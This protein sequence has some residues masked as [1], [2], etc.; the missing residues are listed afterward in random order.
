MNAPILSSSD[1]DATPVRFCRAC[2]EPCATFLQPDYRKNATGPLTMSTCV[3]P[4]C[5]LHL[6]TL[7]DGADL[8]PYNVTALYDATTGKLLPRHIRCSNVG[9]CTREDRKL[10]S[11]MR[12]GRDT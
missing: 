3:E 4:S 1:S 8:R 12:T 11:L 2:S 5:D 6:H 9:P 7:S 10:R